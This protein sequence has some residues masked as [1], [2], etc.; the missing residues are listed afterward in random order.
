MEVIVC[1]LQEYIRA[2][3]T[4]ISGTRSRVPAIRVPSVCQQLSLEECQAL[5]GLHALTGCD[6]VSSFEGKR[7]KEALGMVKNAEQ[8]SLASA[9]VFHQARKILGESRSS[10]ARCT[11][12]LT[13][14]VSMERD[15]SCSARTRNNSHTS[16]LPPMPLYRNISGVP[17]IKLTS[18][19]TGWRQESPTNNQKVRDGD[20]EERRWRT[21]GQAWHQHQN[22]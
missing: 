9:T 11:M 20:L 3:L 16:F 15:T 12:T 21:T 7:K 19:N 8:V 6:S 10:C 13:V 22:W 1:Y 14:E 4:L 5:P 17:T 2:D 18:G